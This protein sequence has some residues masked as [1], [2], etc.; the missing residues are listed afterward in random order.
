MSGLLIGMTPSHNG[1]ASEIFLG[2]YSYLGAPLRVSGFATL[3]IWSIPPMTIRLS[4]GYIE[5]TL[6]ALPRLSRG[7][8]AGVILQVSR[9]GWGQTA[10]LLYVLKLRAT[11]IGYEPALVVY[12]SLKPLLGETYLLHSGAHLSYH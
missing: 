8:F 12:G 11:I 1:V 10:Q 6:V 7:Y 9:P 3:P 2:L 4:I 5:V